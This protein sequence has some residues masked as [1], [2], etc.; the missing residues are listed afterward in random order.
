M[1]LDEQTL[2]ESLATY[3]NGVVMTTSDVDRMQKDL[4]PRLRTARGSGRRRLLIAAAAVLLLIAAIAAGTL[5]L[6]RAE[7]VVP[8]APPS[9]QGLGPIP[10]ITMEVDA[11]G[12]NLGALHADGTAGNFPG[13]SNIVHPTPS[14][15]TLRWH[16]DGGSGITE[17]VD[18]QG[19]RCTK[20]AAFI[21]VSEGVIR[22]AAG[23]LEGPACDSTASPPST[24]TWLSPASATGIALKAD[25]GGQP[26]P[27]TDA[28]QLNGVWL[29]EGT[30][31]LLASDQV[32]GGSG[33]A[34]YR[35]DDDG[36]IDVAPDATGSLTLATD[37][38]ITLTSNGCADTVLENPASTGIDTRS[39]LTMTVAADPCKRFGG[40]TVL[41]WVKV[42]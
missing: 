4:Q 17:F 38:R 2:R 8:A 37:K 25:S 1:S 13:E 26:L 10:A 19:R 34:D 40:K 9:P 29:L 35:L 33:E 14:T 5:W 21:A 42:L 15:S 12:S 11:T 6:R 30:G 28:V 18:S 3:A 32:R 22:F 24:V 41:T 23:R 7:P 27:V 36:D 39:A 20:T 16:V 31:L